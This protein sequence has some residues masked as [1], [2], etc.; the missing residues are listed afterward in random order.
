MQPSE[1]RVA[2]QKVAEIT[3]AT[4]LISEITEST[5]AAPVRVA[6]VGT[7]RPSHEDP[8]AD[9]PLC[10]NVSTAAPLA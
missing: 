4:P 6:H 7:R 5:A 3:P 8:Y 10:I 9:T 2:M 1:L